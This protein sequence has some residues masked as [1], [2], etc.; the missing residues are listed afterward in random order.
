MSQNLFRQISALLP[1]APVYVGRVIAH[2][3]DDT[4]TIEIPVNLATV[5]VGGGLARGSLIRPRGRTVPIGGWAFV[6]RGVIETHA[7]TPAPEAV[8]VGAPVGPPFTWFLDNFAGTASSVL[9]GRVSDSGDEWIDTPF[10]DAAA[11]NDFELDGAGV[12]KQKSPYGLIRSA[13]TL[14]SEGT[15]FWLEAD[16]QFA[17]NPSYPGS[18][19]STFEAD[20]SLDI[21]SSTS[22]AAVF[23]RFAVQNNDTF[24]VRCI[25]RNAGFAEEYSLTAT[26]SIDPYAAHTLRLEGNAGW[27]EWT[28]KIDGTTVGSMGPFT[29]PPAAL[30]VFEMFG[31]PADTT[32][33]AGIVS[34]ARVQTGPL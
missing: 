10:G 19:S 5:S 28:V 2:H 25:A 1:D 22:S 7:P 33:T 18:G 34:V 30:D 8:A 32:T 14:P 13:W 17:D 26:P 4:S 11:G 15:A 12:A 31:E 23:F 27:T 29:V 20:W 16:V 24:L 6:R 3:E 21:Y 9:L